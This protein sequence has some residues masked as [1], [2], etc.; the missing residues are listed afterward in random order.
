MDRKC[1]K[2]VKSVN[3]KVIVNEKGKYIELKPSN[4]WQLTDH[5]ILDLIA[6]CME[7]Q[8]EQ[9]LLHGEALT[10]DFFKLGTG[11]AGE[12]LQKLV[13]YHIT[14]AA[15]IS[16][17]LSNKGRFREMALEANKSSHFRIFNDQ[18]AAEA[19]LAST[20]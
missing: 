12:I 3:Y 19:W 11:V 13:N 18:K 7:N 10:E 4:D 14:T 2:G 15:V 8:S 5:N 16:D 1:T 20:I 17:E 6:V 9:L